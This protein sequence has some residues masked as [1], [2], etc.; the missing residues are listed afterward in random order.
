MNNISVKQTQSISLEEVSGRLDFLW[1]ELTARCNLK[2]IHCYAESAPI[3]KFQ[4]KLTPQDYFRLIDEASFL[5][6]RK[7][8]FIGGEP[9]LVRELPDFIKHAR[10]RGFEFIEVFTNGTTISDKLL[11]CFMDNDVAVAISFYSDKAEIHDDI[12]KKF[13]SHKATLRNIKRILGA[14]LR[15]RAGI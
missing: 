3:P 2:C 9:T 1:L 7:I 4:D 15:I 12:T 11:Q 5:A 13:G 6:C 14:G 8:Q 10:K